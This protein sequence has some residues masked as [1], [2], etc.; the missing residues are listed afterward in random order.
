MN[1]LSRW[2]KRLIDIICSGLLLLLLSPLF[3]L[4]SIAVWFKLG[5]PVIFR[6]SRPG[7]K[8]RV[9]DM[10][11]FRT[12]SDS[13]DGNGNLLPD[14]ERLLSFGIGLRRSSLDELPELINVLIG[15]MS[16][17]GPRP[18]LTSYMELYND[19]Q[20][21]R[22]EVRPGITGWA[23]I[24]GRNTI[25]WEEKFELDVWYIDNWSLQLDLKI[26]VQ[27]L[28]KVISREGI[29][30]EGEATMTLFKGSGPR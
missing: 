27:T 15:D 18:L 16:M 10:Y 12:M 4:I 21:R 17:V 6:Q 23:Q 2:I 9:F 14:S 7:L 13:T 19:E 3:M 24:N 26:L 5:S 28:W 22:H 29:S 25:S 30:A 11:K 20:S 1:K 8:G